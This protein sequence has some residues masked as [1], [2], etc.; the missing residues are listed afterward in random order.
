VSSG[1]SAAHASTKD[2]APREEMERLYYGLT[3][4]F[5]AVFC[6]WKP[7]GELELPH[8]VA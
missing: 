5:L 6:L 3:Q 8:G 1:Q 4:I 2:F 7:A